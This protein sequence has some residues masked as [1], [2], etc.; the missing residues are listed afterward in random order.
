M[1]PKRT[2][3]GGGATSAP[4]GR[5]WKKAR[6]FRT[7]RKLFID[8]ENQHEESIKSRDQKFVIWLALVTD[9]ALQTELITQSY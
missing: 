8:L 3:M 4:L 2:D 7:K 6:I 9:T 5:Q 1:A